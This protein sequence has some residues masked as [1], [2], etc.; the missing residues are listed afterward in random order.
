MLQILRNF[1]GRESGNHVFFYQLPPDIVPSQQ[2]L[3]LSI[4][5]IVLSLRKIVLS[6]EK[7][8]PSFLLSF[9]YTC[10]CQKHPAH[11]AYPTLKVK[12]LTCGISGMSGLFSHFHFTTCL[13]NR[14]SCRLSLP[15][16]SS[17]RQEQLRRL[18]RR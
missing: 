3:R 5:K 18:R 1:N 14:P 12:I 15:S 11:P 7:L 10:V 4:E 9:P 2:K 17:S 13:C 6:I 8:R 16:G